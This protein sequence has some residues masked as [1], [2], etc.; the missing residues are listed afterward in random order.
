MR[1]KA[2]GEMVYV[3]MSQEG[4]K[5]GK[6]WRPVAVVTNPE[7]A[8]QWYQY[9]KDVDWVPLGLDEIQDINPEKMPAFQP[10]KLTPGEERAAELSKNMEETIGRLQAVIEQQQ[11][12]IKKLQKSKGVKAAAENIPPKPAGFDEGLPDGQAIADY[13]ETYALYPV[14]N[15]YVYEIFR[16]T[17]AVL[18]LVPLAELQEGGRDANQR[19]K[20]NE[21]K[22]LKQDLSTQP[23]ALV[24]NGKVWDGN[25]RFRANQRRGLTAMWCYVVMEGDYGNDDASGDQ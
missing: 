8:E 3:L 4:G 23:P 5:K 6:E 18:K 17:H 24:E 2:K 10:R 25:H 22:Y 13:V 16:G 7:V 14:D 9:G 15:E 1:K 19:S 11:A 21:D 20:K 12:T